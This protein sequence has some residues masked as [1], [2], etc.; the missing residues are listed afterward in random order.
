MRRQLVRLTIALTATLGGCARGILPEPTDAAA[1][2]CDATPAQEL[3]AR[4]N[5]IR[6]ERGLPE[7]LVDE[8]LAAAA[9]MHS[10]DL[11]RRDAAGHLGGDG[12]LADVRAGRKGYA[13]VFI[14]ENVAVG[15][16]AASQVIMGWMSSADHRRNLLSHEARHVGVGYAYRP[17]TR[18]RHFWTAV[19][20]SSATLT[21]PSEGCDP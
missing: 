4:T 15:Q 3:V 14:A 8:R 7:L 16:P 21:E 11:A 9:R 20:G 19:Y 12:S 1:A 5:S 6:R 13:W 17:G 2:A 18:W 10:A